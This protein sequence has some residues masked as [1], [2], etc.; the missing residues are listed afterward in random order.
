MLTVGMNLNVQYCSLKCS[1]QLSPYVLLSYNYL[2]LLFF[3]L[4]VTG[5]HILY[6]HAALIRC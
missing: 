1:M 3:F 2:H 4:N 6:T 5:A